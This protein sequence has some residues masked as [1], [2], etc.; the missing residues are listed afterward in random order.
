MYPFSNRPT[1]ANNDCVFRTLRKECETVTGSL[2]TKEIIAHDIERRTLDVVTLPPHIS[3][4]TFLNRIMYIVC[5]PI[6]IPNE[7]KNKHKKTKHTNKQKQNTN[8]KV[9]MYVCYTI[10]P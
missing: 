5:N 3:E 8:A 1:V 2:T 6:L 7:T 4:S 10:A 9:W